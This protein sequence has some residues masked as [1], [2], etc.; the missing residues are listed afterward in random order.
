MRGPLLGLVIDR[1]VS[2]VSVIPEKVA[3]P[4][5]PT[6]FVV[7]KL[8]MPALFKFSCPTLSV[9]LELNECPPLLNEIFSVSML[10]SGDNPEMAL[11]V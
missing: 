2:P 3:A 6:P 10:L 8:T 5:E 7:F 11:N 1:D 4:D 9:W